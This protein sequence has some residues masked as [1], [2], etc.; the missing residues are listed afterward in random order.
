MNV[1]LYPCILWFSL[2]MDVFVL[3]IACFTKQFTICLGV[4]VPVI[5]MCI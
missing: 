5:L 4:V 3:C 1:M 2:L